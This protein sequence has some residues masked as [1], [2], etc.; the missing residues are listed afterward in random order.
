[1]SSNN[2]E[3]LDCKHKIVIEFRTSLDLLNHPVIKQMKED[4]IAQLES[5]CDGAYD[6]DIDCKT[7]TLNTNYVVTRSYTYSADNSKY[8]DDTFRDKLFNHMTNMYIMAE[9][10]PSDLDNMSD[11]E[12]TDTFE[13]MTDEDNELL[14]EAKA[15][16]ATHKML[17]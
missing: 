11:S 13:C 4:M 3:A 6:Y 5:M 8:F 15:Q 9:M 1:M 16:I 7:N 14:I 2:N 17:T 12:L 10:D